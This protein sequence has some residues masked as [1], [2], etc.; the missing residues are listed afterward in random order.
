MKLID[1]IMNFLGFDKVLGARNTIRWR[2]RRPGNNRPSPPPPPPSNDPILYLLSDMAHRD[3]IKEMLP[4]TP[5]EKP[6]FA[7]KNYTGGGKPLGS[8]EGQAA[9]CFVTV[10]NTLNFT[11]EHTDKHLEGWAGTNTL[12]VVPRAGVDL[13]AYYDRRHLKFFYA[14]HEAIGGSIFTCDSSDIVAHELGH[15][16]LDSYRPETWDAVSL[17]VWSFHEA[18]ADLTAIMNMLSH[19]EILELLVNN[20]TNM[21]EPN[22][23]SNLA[24]HMGEVIYKIAGPESGR[25]PSC[26][27]CAI[28]DFKYVDPAGLP[29]EAPANQLAAECHSF[30]RVFLGAFYDIFVMMY[31]EAKE[32]MPPVEALRHARSTLWRYTLKA[33]QNAPVTVKFYESMARTMLWAD[34]VLGERKYHDKMQEIFFARNLLTPE[35]KALSGDAPE[36]DNDQGIMFSSGSAT[37]K[38]SDFVLTAQST[39]PLYNVELTI[40]MD[41]VYLYDGDRNLVD[42]FIS[43]LD[44]DSAEAAVWHLHNMGLVSDSPNTPFE[45]KD[46]KLVRTHI[47]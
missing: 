29:D 24:E 47:V 39:N 5:P 10:A 31:D 6:I 28:N 23:V 8:V 41:T 19:D 32:T 15:A 44:V 14:S 4:P 2:R 3:L 35:M 22:I 17:E 20:G 45:I 1:N 34:V 36:C 9:N 27:R 30:G 25:N 18:F 33:I 42:A 38:L 16:M 21:R 43:T 13:N 11:R 40:P 46:G 26:L 7:V 12:V 37:L